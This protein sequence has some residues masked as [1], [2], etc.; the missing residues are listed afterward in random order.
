MQR[1]LLIIA[2]A[3]LA[4]AIGAPAAATTFTFDQDPFAGS[5]ALTMPG[6][7]IVA[8][9]AFISFSPA[10]DVFAFDPA[11]F[12]AGDTVAF[13]NDVVGNLPASGRNIIVLET[14]DNDGDAGTP[15]LAG[16]AANLIATQVTSDGAGF[17][18]YFNSALNLPRLVYS[19]N[20]S[21]E[22]ADLKILARLTNL[23]GQSG[24]L[25]NLSA[26]NFQ[27]LTP[28]P[29]PATWAT[30]ILGLGLIGAAARRRKLAIG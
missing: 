5:T 16:N 13:A 30:M 27:F 4:L 12:A 21:D 24:E 8:G 11:V 10:A 20:L 22:T 25:A 28:V 6:R 29:E 14:F 1:P 19:T 26:A 18:I 15:F 2:T 17:F 23:T 3:V 9:E 7:Q